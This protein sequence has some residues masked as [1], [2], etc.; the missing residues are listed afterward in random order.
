MMFENNPIMFPIV[1]GLIVLSI[2][3]I[4]HAQFGTVKTYQTAV[5]VKKTPEYSAKETAVDDEDEDDQ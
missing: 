2:I 4:Y 5:D 1:V 3:C